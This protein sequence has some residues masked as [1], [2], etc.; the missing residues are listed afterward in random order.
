[1]PASHNSVQE[2]PNLLAPRV[3]HL[4][5]QTL[6]TDIHELLKSALL[7]SLQLKGIA[8]YTKF[9]PEIDAALRWVVYRFTLVESRTSVGHKLLQMKYSESVPK[10]V[11]KSYALLLV[12]IP[13]LH[14]RKGDISKLFIANEVKRDKFITWCDAVDVVYRILH[15]LNLLLFLREGFYSTIAERFF[16]LRPVPTVPPKLRQISYSFFSREL[17]WSGF[18]ELLGFILPLIPTQQVHSVL[19]SLLPKHHVRGQL[20][21]AAEDADLTST[22]ICMLCGDPPVLPHQFGCSHVACHY[23]LYAEYSKNQALTCNQCHYV[24]DNPAHIVPVRTK[25]QI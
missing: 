19:K 18:A 17:L 6:N 4:D 16:R 8:L 13:W 2:Y 20:T 15:L 22:S 3:S 25:R 23:C 24:M 21:A 1:M 5:A 10:H 7:E 14:K 9:E 12:I 11:L